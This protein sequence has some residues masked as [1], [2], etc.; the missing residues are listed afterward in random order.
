MIK[1]PTTSVQKGNVTALFAREDGFFQLNRAEA[2][3]FYPK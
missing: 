3:L 1:S 2:A